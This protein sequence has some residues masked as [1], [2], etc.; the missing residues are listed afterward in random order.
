M[1]ARIS[2]SFFCAA[3]GAALMYSSMVFGRV[4]FADMNFFGDSA[5]ATAI[6][7]SRSEF[8]LRWNF[9]V[10]DFSSFDR[11]LHAAE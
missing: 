8:T 7:A 3:L 2:R 10:A 5:S 11:S 9:R 1:H 4:F 6:V